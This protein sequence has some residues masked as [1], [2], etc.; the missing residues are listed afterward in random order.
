MPPV[1]PRIIPSTRKGHRTNQLVAPH[2]FIMAISSRRVK[3]ASLMVLAMM[4]ME[5]STSITTRMMAKAVAT[6]RSMT[7]PSA[8]SREACTLAMPS[9]SFTWSTVSCISWMSTT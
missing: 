9:M 4:E 6:L 1:R 2:I 8:I 7:K 3:V 5:M